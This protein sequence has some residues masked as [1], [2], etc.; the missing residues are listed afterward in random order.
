L[1][2]LRTHHSMKT[3]I[4]LLLACSSVFAAETDIRVFSIA[5]TNAENGTVYTQDVFTRGG[6]T[7][8]TRSQH[9]VAG[10]T[11][12]A[13]F[14]YHDGQIAGI[15][16][17]R[18]GEWGAFNTEPGPYC[19]SL[20]YGRSGEIVSAKIG[21]KNGILVDEFSYTNGMFSPVEGPLYRTHMKPKIGS[22]ADYL[23]WK[24]QQ[25]RFQ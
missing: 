9:V 11:T 15:Y 4:L 7:N 22:E 20:G 8:L 12:G 24:E 6:Q 17:A 18:E 2:L 5:K 1:V 14:F 21:D 3:L 19:M 23:K 13:C 16:Q 25:K 10:K